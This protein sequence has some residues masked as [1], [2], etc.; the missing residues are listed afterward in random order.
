MGCYLIVML[1]KRAVKKYRLEYGEVVSRRD[2]IL[3]HPTCYQ[4]K[5][6]ARKYAEKE[7]SH[8]DVPVLIVYE[9][10]PKLDSL[11]IREVVNRKVI[12]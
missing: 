9:Y 3:L 10:D 7:Y 6:S 2:V 12:E 1:K 8:Y 5:W 4:S 11:Y